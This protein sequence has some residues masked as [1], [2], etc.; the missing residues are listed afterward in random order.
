MA[1]WSIPIT[2]NMDKELLRSNNDGYNIRVKGSYLPK[3]RI[4]HSASFSNAA[5]L[6]V[7]NLFI[8]TISA[9][10]IFSI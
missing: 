5:T 8:K 3:G 10:V 1:Q 2:I 7:L 4:C 9:K 6:K